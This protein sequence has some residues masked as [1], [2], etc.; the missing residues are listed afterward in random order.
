MLDDTHV[1]FFS[2][3]GDQMGSQRR[4]GKCVPC[5]ESARVPFIIG[6]GAPMGYEGRKCG[7]MPSL[8]NH[9]DIAPTSLGLCEIKPPDWME[10]F[11]YAHRRTGRNYQERVAEEPESAYLQLIGDRESGYAWR[12]VVT[13]DGW[14]YACV[15]GGEWLL[16]NLNDDPYEQNNLAFHTGYRAKREEMKVLLRQWIEKTG[17]AFPV[18][19]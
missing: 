14:K 2:D 17:D 5:E 7:N 6:G 11:D 18:P 9:V 12:C 19:E 3:H 16:I 13:R 4:F 8:V 10:G 1:I 15:G